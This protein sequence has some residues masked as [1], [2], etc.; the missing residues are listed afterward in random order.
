MAIGA[1]C[2]LAGSHLVT[3]ADVSTG[4][5]TNTGSATSTQAGP[6][7]SNTVVTPVAGSPALAVAKTY[8]GFTDNDGSTTVTLGDS[9]SYTVT[10][11]NTGTSALT[12]VVVSDAQ[13]APNSASCPSV[14]VGATCVLAGSH[15]VTAADVSA[16]NVTNTGSA[17]STQAGPVNSNTVVTPVIATPTLSISSGNN[18][19]GLTSTVADL[20]LVV[21]LLDGS[22]APIAGQTINWAIS[23]AG[24]LSTASTATN[25]AGQTQVT[26][27]FAASA[28]PIKVIASTGGGVA[29]VTFS[30]TAVS[31]SIGIA[32]G[33]GQIGP[34]N[35]TLPLPLKVKVNLPSV[36]PA[37][38]GRVRIQAS[39]GV[40]VTYTVTSGGGSVS[41]TTVLTDSNGEAATL[42][43][44]GP[45]PGT[46]TVRASIP[47]GSNITFTATATLDRSL[48]LVAG[49]GQTA[50]PGNTLPLPLVVRAQ[51][52]GSNAP[53]VIISWT[54]VSGSATVSPSASTTN[55]VGQA[56][57]T[58]TLGAVPGAVTIRAERADN[59]A[60]SVLF[61]ANTGKLQIMPGLDPAKLKLAI[62]L[63]EL[64]SS[65][66]AKSALTPKQADL[67]AR[68]SEL[69]NASLLDPDATVN[70][71][72]QLLPGLAAATAES[73]FNAA[74]AQFQNLKA[75]IAALRSGTQGNGFNGLALT[76][77]GGTISLG[78]LAQSLAGDEPSKPEVGADFQ[79]WG[80]F[81]SGTIGRGEA[82]QGRSRPAYDYDINGITLG[83]DYRQSD[84]FIFGGALGYTRQGTDLVGSPGK[85][86]M[87]G[88]SLSTYA[89]YYRDNSWYSDA[90]LTWGRSKFDLLRTITYT[91]PTPG[92][93]TSR[94]AQTAR[95][96]TDG[97]MLEGAFTFGR[98]FQV[99]GWSMGGYGRMLYTKL[100]FDRI[101]EDL[102]TGPGTGL[103]LAIDARSLTSLA[104]E[105]GAKFTYAHSTTWGVVTPHMQVEWEHEFKNDPKA[106]T[107]RFLADPNGAPF[108]LNGEAID[109]DYFRMS[110]G[111][112]IIMARGRSGFFLYER[113][114][115]RS[116]FTQDNL[117]FGI[118]IE[119]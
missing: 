39:N 79:R 108:T 54:I 31:G 41:T 18:Q 68:C 88:W 9:L 85:M 72:D 22:G 55:S 34:I 11:S 6:V 19:T 48:I 50:A 43:T 16:G 110:V 45:V 36:S 66:A 23:G 58:V 100:N 89:T 93:G 20:P 4:T 32:S 57:S 29:P 2:V 25:G 15:L 51:N 14:A 33:D 96:T 47:G 1:T 82:D 98:D 102:G 91:L 114:L 94:I 118:R 44:L 8:N 109:T 99:G 24:T 80:F 101:S 78:A 46:Q 27:S 53:G 26:L 3:A 104:S 63:D 69:I 67:Y 17:T 87:R 28:G 42:F 71:L 119:F 83:A 95:S 81:A 111:L 56:S 62:V 21:T 86:D 13:L 113:T 92:G 117:G 61:T 35:T 59:P 73:A 7:N 37:A 97:D 75:R 65:L 10:A 64:C 116:G 106:L 38:A 60:T 5:V 49:S 107:A 77:P 112:S 76:G 74:Q 52:N 103:G 90:V 70:A 84:K 30:A 115:G 105:L 40:P 12:N